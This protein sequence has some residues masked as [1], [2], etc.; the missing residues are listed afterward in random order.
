[1]AEITTIARPY[2]EAVFRLADERG[3]LAHWAETLSAMAQVAGNPD[4]R[5]CIDNPKLT[6]KQLIELFASLCKGIDQEGMNLASTLVENRRLALLPEIRELFEELKNQREGVLE[7]Q[8]FSAFA[9]DDAQ[10]A[11]LVADLERKFGRRISA[12]VAVDPGL[13][14]GVKVVIGDQVIDASV[15]AKLAAMAAALKA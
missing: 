2:A 10:S 8:V 1:M 12:S 3:R 7:A 4:M 14:G 9:L 5:A 6:A 13:I 15:R 11:R